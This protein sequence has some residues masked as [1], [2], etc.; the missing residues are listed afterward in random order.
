MDLLCDFVWDCWNEQVFLSDTSRNE[1]EK[2]N[3]TIVQ[4][5][6]FPQV[7]FF[8]FPHT[9]ILFNPVSSRYFITATRLI[10][11]NGSSADGFFK[12]LPVYVVSNELP[13]RSTS[14]REKQKDVIILFLFERGLF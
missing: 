9:I 14:F 8:F 10:F 12:C 11:L 2:I 7:F 5:G 1:S 6:F 3:K 13:V 4:F